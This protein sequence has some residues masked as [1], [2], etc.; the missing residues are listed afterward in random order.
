MLEQI[1]TR[2]GNLSFYLGGK[3]LSNLE[4]WALNIDAVRVIVR[5]TIATGQLNAEIETLV[6]N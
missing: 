4:R 6:N 5:Y 2:R 3:T 1:E